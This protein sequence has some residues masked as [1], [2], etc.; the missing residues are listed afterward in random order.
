MF[1]R[2]IR[3]AISLG[4][5]GASAL[6]SWAGDATAATTVAPLVPSLAL[7]VSPGLL[8]GVAFS[9]P[10]AMLLIGFIG[11]LVTDRSS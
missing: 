11:V 8:F 9:A 5:V 7:C 2:T 4:L 3:P 10:M 1:L 6:A